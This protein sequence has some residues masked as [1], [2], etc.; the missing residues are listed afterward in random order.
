MKEP[1]M[2]QIAEFINDA[3]KSCDDGWKLKE[4][5]NKVLA[6]T[7]KFPLYPELLRW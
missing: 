1:Q 3:I 5:K 7:K 4:I 6:L 2:R